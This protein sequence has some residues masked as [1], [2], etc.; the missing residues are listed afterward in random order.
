[1]R[2]KSNPIPVNV[3]STEVDEGIF[4]ARSSTHGPPEFKEVERSH[5]D[6]GHC[7]FLQ[8]KGT[9]TIEIDFQEYIVTAPSIVYIHPNQV[10]RVIEF[11][12]AT[13]SSWII[14]IEN[15][16]P[17]YLRLLE[18]IFPVNPLKLTVEE[19][20]L[21]AATASL[22]LQFSERT[23]DKLYFPI[24]KESCNTLV[25]LAISQYLAQPKINDY[26]SRFEVITKGFKSA[27]EEN[28]KSIK[29]PM[30]YAD[31]LNISTP[32]LNECVKNST[33]YSV[34]YHIQ[35]RVILEAKRLLFHSNCSVKEISSDLGYEDYAY[36]VR[37]F[38]KVT[39]MTPLTFRKKNRD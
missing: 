9:T 32:Y 16:H 31:Q 18:E 39:G 20:A 23:H 28:Y 34:S 24:L 11:N 13:I 6:S 37:L 12:Q 1:M 36:F 33:G 21:L 17:Q 15:L 27:L 19:Y 14:T 8:E 38:V 25:A 7:F 30:V 22:C 35:Q 26:A 29:S 4:I 5:R 3:L 10:H 2:E